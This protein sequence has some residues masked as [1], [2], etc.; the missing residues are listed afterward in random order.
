MGQVRVAAAVAVLA[1]SSFVPN[2]NMAAQPLD[3]DADPLARLAGR[4]VGNAVMTQTSG[5]P[6]NFKCVVTYL[7]QKDGPGMQQ[8]LRCDNGAD[9]KLH[10]A[11]ELLVSGGKVTGRWQDKINEIDG[12][13][14]GNVTAT[15]FEVELQGRFFQARM[16]V[17][18]QGCDQSVTVMPQ[19]SEVFRELAATLKKC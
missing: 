12:T 5:Q 13:V 19:K 4:W 9:F 6:A 3:G 15:G 2:E 11:T 17:A 8:N 16:A 1:L 7:P 18:G 10:A 14:A